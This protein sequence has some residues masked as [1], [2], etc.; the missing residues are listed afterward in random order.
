MAYQGFLIK[1]G[2]YTIP[3]NMIQYDSYKP[4]ISVQDLDSYSDANG[5]LHRNVVRG[6]HSDAP[7]KVEFNTRNN[8]TNDKLAEFLFM[9]HS[10]FTN[11]AERKSTVTMFI[12]EYNDYV[13]QEM[14]MPDVQPTINRIIDGVIYY[15]PIRLAFIGY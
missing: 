7:A 1:V 8:I 14:Y 15:D 11:V 4:Y 9:I 3:L 6:F 5:H 10:Q 12:P 2:E 13:T